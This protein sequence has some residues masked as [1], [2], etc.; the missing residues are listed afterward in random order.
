MAGL[1][2]AAVGLKT[3]LKTKHYKLPSR[4][5]S[6]MDFIMI[7]YVVSNVQREDSYKSQ[8]VNTACLLRSSCTAGTGH[9]VERILGT[10]DWDPDQKVGVGG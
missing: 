6:K 4:K 2:L 7:R 5:I 1:S 10:G 8:N 9:T 3:G